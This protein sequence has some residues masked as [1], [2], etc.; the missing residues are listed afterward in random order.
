MIGTP[1]VLSSAYEFKAAAGS[2]GRVVN[3]EALRAPS[4]SAMLVEDIQLHVTGSF[5]LVD[6]WH[7]WEIKLGRAPLTSFFV[8]PELCVRREE[9]RRPYADA[10][11][12]AFLWSFARPLY[13][14]AGSTLQIKVKAALVSSK[15]VVTLRGRVLPENYPQPKFVDVPFATM[16]RPQAWTPDLTETD[17]L[18]YIYK[19]G[20]QDVSNPF[21]TPLNVQRFV[22][23]A[24]GGTTDQVLDET[25]DQDLF[26]TFRY[27]PRIQVYSQNGDPVSRDPIKLA[28]F[29]AFGRSTLESRFVL[30]PR[31]VIYL[32]L[33]Q[34]HIAE[35]DSLGHQV[36]IG[37]VGWRQVPI[38]EVL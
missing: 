14:P 17:V 6:V 5:A 34:T 20:A 32:T 28:Q 38:S 1:V 22:M 15:A 4:R 26:G 8:P 11:A 9:I 30:P 16:F 25:P 35:H 37:M 12:D 19:S 18:K 33:D 29:C 31:E 7:E 23:H 21:D 24:V 27:F 13:L 2:I 10:S 36:G 3:P